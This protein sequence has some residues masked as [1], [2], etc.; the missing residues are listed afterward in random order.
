VKRV[1]A[2]LLAFVSS[3][4]AVEQARQALLDVL[5]RDCSTG[6]QNHFVADTLDEIYYWYRDLPDVDPDAYASPEAYLDAVRKR[7]LD[8]AFSYITSRAEDE[9][10]RARSEYVG[11]GFGSRLVG[12]TDL[13]V[14]HVY[15]RSAAADA[16]L[17]RGSQVLAVNGRTVEEIV[18]AGDLDSAFGPA[19]SGVAVAL[20]FLTRAGELR[21]VTATKRVVEVPPVG[22]VRVHA[23]DGRVVGYVE[24]T[25]FTEPTR[26]ALDAAFTQLR[27]AGA[28]ELVLDVRY[29]GGGLVS[30]AQHLAGLIGGRRTE[31]QVLARLTHND[32]N[33]RRDQDI[34]FPNPPAALAVERLFVIT[35]RSS[36]SASEL[37]IN[38]LRPH[39]TVVQV[40]D[41]SYG[42]PVGQYSY[43][44]CDKVLHPVAF[45]VLNS[46]GEGN[47][48]DGLAPACRA[49]DDLA[50]DLGDAGEASLAEALGYVRSGSCS[51]AAAATARAQAVRRP[52]ESRQPHRGDGWQELLG[53]W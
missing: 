38:G 14:T 29:N 5:L 39:F 20:R 32:K 21:E 48:F 13:R 15:P 25:N 36:A 24:L 35:T 37:M 43:D 34:R 26:A 10:L 44:F 50:F 41:D 19:E 22:A 31:G 4:C 49:A 12:P 17:D 40:G 7:P 33:S 1:A 51:P 18:A 45:N 52:P 53:A 16:G 42:K 2:V 11:L 46:R 9:A 47:Y 27:A 23:V 30:I 28:T 6:G 8:D 3:A